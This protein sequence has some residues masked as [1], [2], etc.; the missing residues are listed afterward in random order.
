L[1][2]SNAIEAFRTSVSA[3]Y[4]A[5]FGRDPQFYVCEVVDGAGEVALR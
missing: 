1:V 3:D 2:E 5:S 4:Q